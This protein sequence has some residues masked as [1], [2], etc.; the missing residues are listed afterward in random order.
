MSSPVGRDATLPQTWGLSLCRHGEPNATLP[1]RCLSL[2]LHFR[3]GNRPGATQ[4]L[5]HLPAGIHPG[6]H[7]V[8]Q[9]QIVYDPY[10]SVCWLANGD[11][12]GD[13]EIRAALG[14]N[15]INPNGSM[16][17]VTAQ[18]LRRAAVPSLHLLAQFLNFITPSSRILHLFQGTWI[19]ASTST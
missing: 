7:P 14:V 16:H 11:L 9:A 1:R 18:N 19:L 10:Q 4:P 12:A 17:Y 6:G 8:L 5:P 3:H 13:P 2:S 15:G